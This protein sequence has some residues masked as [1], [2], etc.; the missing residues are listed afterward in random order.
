[1]AIRIQDKQL[2]E[3]FQQLYDADLTD[4]S[5]S[6]YV[7]FETTDQR[8]HVIK[9]FPQLGEF[10]EDEPK[11]PIDF[12]CLAIYNDGDWGWHSDW[13]KM[14]YRVCS[15]TDFLDACGFDRPDEP[16]AVFPT[17]LADP[18]ALFDL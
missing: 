9:L 18:S 10:Y 15:Y 6:A 17:S 11:L 13:V 5:V 4:D 12:M 7:E 8:D 14:Q 3:V 1:M 2:Y 16:S